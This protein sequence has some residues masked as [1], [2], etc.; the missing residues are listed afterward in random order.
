LAEIEGQEEMEES[1]KELD[2]IYARAKEFERKAKLFEVLNSLKDEVD[3]EVP[4]R[5]N[6]IKI[7]AYNLTE[8][9][10]LCIFL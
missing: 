3:A 6:A 9:K 8:F 10:L 7:D 2:S 4:K 5:P 1:M